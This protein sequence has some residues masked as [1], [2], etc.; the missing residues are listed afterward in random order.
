MRCWIAWLLAWGCALPGFGQAFESFSEEYNFYTYLLR[1]DY[2]GEAFTVLE[3]LSLRPGLTVGQRDT[4]QYAMG[5]FHYERQE[6]LLAAEAFG[7]VSSTNTELWTEAVFFRAFGLAYSG[8]PNI[9]I[10]ELD[11]VTFKDP[12]YQELKV[13]QQAGMALLARDFAAYE[14]YKQGFT[15]TYF[16]FAEEEKNSQQW[17][18][19]LQNFPGKRPWLAGT[20]SAIVPGLG[21]VYANKWGQG[22][23]TFMQVG[24]FGAQAWEGYRKDGLV[25]WR[26]ITFAAVGSIFYISNV[27]GSVFAAQQRNQEFYEAVDYRLKLDLHMPLRTLFR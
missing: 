7:E 27:V 15:G 4:V 19:D 9:A 5:R 16:A 24:V 20:L 25:S 13:Y 17:A 3:K 10:Q 26:F 1:E 6:L 14:Q 23:A 8:Q 2:P 21:R 12:Q 22:L 11:Q 18:D